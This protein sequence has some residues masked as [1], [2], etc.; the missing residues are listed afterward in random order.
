MRISKLFVVI[1]LSLSIDGICQTESQLLTTAYSKDSAKLFESV[2]DRW[3]QTN[4]QDSLPSPQTNDTILDAYQVFKDFFKPENFDTIAGTALSKK[5]YENH[6]YILVQNSI[7]ICFTNRVYYSQYEADSIGLD[8]SKR[9]LMKTSPPQSEYEFMTKN[10]GRMPIDMIRSNAKFKIAEMNPVKHRATIN[11][12][13][14]DI[15]L[16]DKKVI[17]LNGHIDTMTNEFLGNRYMPGGVRVFALSTQ[18]DNTKRKKALEQY[19][20]IWYGKKNDNW[21][22]ISYPYVQSITFDKNRSYALLKIKFPYLDGNAL[23][24]RESQGWKVIQFEHR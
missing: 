8:Y 14:P 17:Y 19:M 1:F 20:K 12:F 18:S 22:L 21:Q 4:Q 7:E 3:Y 6:S 13:R 15:R 5:N 11:D 10:Y 24:K 2:L 9:Q 16:P 23:M